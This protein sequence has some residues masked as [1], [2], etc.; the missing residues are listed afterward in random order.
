[1]NMQ[2]D[3]HVEDVEAAISSDRPVRDHGPY[4]IKVGDEH[5]HYQSLVIEEVQP[6][7]KQILDAAGKH[8][9][10]EYVLFRLLSDGLMEE[11]GI[12]E[13][14][15][16]RRH[17]VEK[18][19]FFNTATIYR[20]ELNE[21]GFEWGAVR[22]SGRTLKKLAGIDVATNDVFEM[23]Q[24]QERLIEDKEL[25]DLSKPGLERFITRPIDIT[26]IVN[27]RP[28]QV[29]QRRLGYWEVVRLAFP[30]AVAKP[31]V[32][33]TVTYSKGPPQNPSGNLQDKQSVFIKERMVFDVTATDE[34]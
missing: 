14:T 6:T 20:F 8:P 26:I 19:L 33:Y 4:G 27:T 12:E 2:F 9:T 13:T 17:G 16:L 34:S 10:I 30:D 32:I 3:D 28:R 25:I 24:S 21:R 5:L 29:H 11:I 15:D 7:G 23:G 31:K 22:I 1:M 18:F